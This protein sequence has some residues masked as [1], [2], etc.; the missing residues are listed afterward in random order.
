MG[1]L[2]FDLI[3]GTMHFLLDIGYCCANPDGRMDPDKLIGGTGGG[4]QDADP[5]HQ[6][7]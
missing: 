7:E 1:L 4:Q 6:P 3:G 2:Q 5:D